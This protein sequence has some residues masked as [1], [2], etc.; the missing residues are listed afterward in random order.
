MADSLTDDRILIA[1]G[2]IGGLSAAISLANHG[3]SSHVLERSSTFST[4]GAGIQLGPNATRILKEWGVLERLLP[5][6]VVCEEILIGDGLTGELLTR[7]QFGKIAEQR[8]G[9]PFLLVH[10]ADLHQAL[11]NT[12]K[13]KPGIK[14]ALECEARSYEQ[15]PDKLM[16]KTMTGDMKG[17]ALIAADGLWSTL[18]QQI[19]R[20]AVL[21]FAGKTAWRTLV[22]PDHLPAELQGPRTGVWLS[23]NVHLV[24]Y[25]VLGGKKINLV[26]VVDERWGGRSEGWAQEADPKL[27]LPAFAKWDKRIENF[28]N[29]GTTW[30]KWSLFHLPPLRTWTQGSVT[31]LGDAAHPMLPFLAQGGAMAIEDAFVLARVLAEHDDDPW[32]AFRHF[33]TARIKR[34]A[35]TAYESRK[36]GNIYHM[37]GVLRLARNFV[38]RRSSPRSVL[39]KLDWL[40]QKNIEG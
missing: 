26:A 29:Y 12:A 30:R 11:L 28:V 33:E 23:S 20:G 2:G 36:M 7:V 10:R 1:G 17:R 39:K 5:N 34:T 40:Y 21:S 6:S 38:M 19:D 24:H 32:S 27:L 15:F 13:K 18:R 31:L 25:P 37:S 4:E 22:D 8:Y 9:G 35:R 14:I 3:I 16:L